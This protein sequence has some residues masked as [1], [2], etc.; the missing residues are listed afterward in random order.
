MIEPTQSIRKHPERSPAVVWGGMQS[1][2]AVIVYDAPAC[3]DYS[4]QTTL[5]SPERS[6][7]ISM[8]PLE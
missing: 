5:A 8:P 1:K 6:R 7:R 4:Q 3:F 2:G